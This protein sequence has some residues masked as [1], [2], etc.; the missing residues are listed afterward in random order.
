MWIFDAWI[1]ITKQDYTD[2]EKQQ[3]RKNV[4]LKCKEST[5]ATDE[6]VAAMKAHEI[7]KT[8]TAKCTK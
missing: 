3:F 7:P 1:F 6:D 8:Q 4:V 5:Q 2:E